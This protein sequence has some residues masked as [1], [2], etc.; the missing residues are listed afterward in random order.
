MDMKQIFDGFDPAQYEQEAEQR[1]GHTDAYQES[2]K[3]TKH[4]TE[5][6][7]KKL[8]AEQSAVYADAVAAMKA[9]KLPSDEAAMDVAER[10]RL[11]IDRWFY[12]CSSSMHVGLAALY[13]SDSRYAAN[14]DKYGAGLTSFLVE[15]IRANAGRSGEWWD[16]WGRS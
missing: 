3:R 8:A 16:V 7:W 2:M 6:D 12:P 11:L 4:Y 15:A 1:W 5:G 10:H 14:I 13:E 9:G